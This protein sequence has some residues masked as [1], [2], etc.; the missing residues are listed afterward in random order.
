MERRWS[1][2]PVGGVGR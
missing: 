1:R 2:G